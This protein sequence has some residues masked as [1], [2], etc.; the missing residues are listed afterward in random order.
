[1]FFAS[2]SFLL[3]S[4]LEEKTI[5]PIYTVSVRDAIVKQV[6]KRSSFLRGVDSIEASS[7]DFLIGGIRAG[8]CGS[9]MARNGMR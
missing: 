5:I 7:E 6:F 4:R 1:M 3:E 2:E 9:L 8:L